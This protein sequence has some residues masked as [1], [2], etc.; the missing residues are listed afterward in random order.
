MLKTQTVFK[1]TEFFN[2]NNC[3]RCYVKLIGKVSH[4]KKIIT[5]IL[6]NFSTYLEKT[7]VLSH[8]KR[9]IIVRDWPI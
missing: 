9:V 6:I 4:K 7:K 8:M 5:N 3:V 2:W 1:Y